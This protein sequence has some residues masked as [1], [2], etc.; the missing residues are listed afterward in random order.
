MPLWRLRAEAHFVIQAGE[1]S[2]VVIRV[3]TLDMAR[4]VRVAGEVLRQSSATKSW[5]SHRREIVY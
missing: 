4:L 5:P 2:R 3:V 1:A